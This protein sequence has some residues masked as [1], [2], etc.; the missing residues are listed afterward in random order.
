MEHQHHSSHEHA[1]NITHEHT[2]HDSHN[3][4]KGH[5]VADF[6]KRLIISTIISIPVLILSSMM[7]SWFDSGVSFPSDKYVPAVLFTCIFIY[8]GYQ[9][10]FSP[11]VGTVLMNL[12]TIVGIINAK[13]LK[14]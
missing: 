12:N 11:A 6:W 1:A 5:N 8:G 3:K 13:L 7:Q 14:V 4:Q 10:R 2:G 9:F